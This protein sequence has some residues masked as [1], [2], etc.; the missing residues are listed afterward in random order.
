MKLNGKIAIV[1]GGAKGI[2]AAIALEFANAGA[3]VIAADMG[4]MT[5]EQENVVPYS[6]N[7]T[8]VDGCK[9]FFDEIITKYGRK[10]K[11]WNDL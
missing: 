8:D 6:L 11:E 4:Q 3:T 10:K 9:K 7:V 2:G 1:T 5:Y